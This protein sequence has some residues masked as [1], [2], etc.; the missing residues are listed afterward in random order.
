[1]ENR[2][3]NE[4]QHNS[5]VT[6]GSIYLSRVSPVQ[7]SPRRQSRWVLANYVGKKDLWK[8]WVLSLVCPGQNDTH[9]LFTVGHWVVTGGYVFISFSSFVCLFV[10]K[11][12]YT[13]TILLSNEET[14]N[15]VGNPDL[16]QDA[17]IFW[18]TYATAVLA[19][20][21]ATHSVFNSSV[22]IHRL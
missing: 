18:M 8:R 15:F 1:M 7:Y 19:T 16:D 10:S 6:R 3:S 20:V 17:G 2:Q 22:K 4:R 12:D 14:I 9:F 21:K 11:Q 5:A 13:E